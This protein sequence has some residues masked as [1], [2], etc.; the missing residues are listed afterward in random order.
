MK[1]VIL[2][3]QPLNPG[4]L[5]W[6][7]F[8]E[9][10]EVTVYPYTDALQFDQRA[11]QAD[12]LMVN[13]FVLN[14][15]RMARLPALKLILVSATGYNNIDLQAAAE[16]GIAVYNVRDYGT[17]SVSQHVFALLLSCIHQVEEHDQ[18]VKGGGWYTYP[19]FSY[20]KSPVTELYGKTLGLLGFGEIG[21][22]V[23]RLGQAFGMQVKAVVRQ[24]NAPGI[25]GVEYISLSDLWPVADVISLHVPLTESTDGVIN[26]TTL[27]LMKPS[28]ILINTSRGG[29]VVEED[30]LWALENNVI[31]RAAI[32]VIREEPPQR[33]L[34]L[35]H[36]RKILVTPHM[37]WTAREARQRLMGACLSNLKNFM[38]GTS[39]NRV[40]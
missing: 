24:K 17:Q 26:K 39:E 1:I 32:D 2:D 18:W 9:I 11:A 30:L 6:E 37:A 33:V 3:G 38:E 7:E 10:G 20:T 8:K 15:E 35:L 21:R 19:H 25:P 16:K 28:T 23:A 34:P 22:A 36:S 4:D 29:L 27:A 13:K 14:A 5:T 31:H 12:V 40:V